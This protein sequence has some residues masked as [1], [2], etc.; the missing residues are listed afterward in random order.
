MSQYDGKIIYIKGKQN[1]IADALSWI[2]T[3]LLETTEESLEADNLAKSLFH[4]ILINGK[5]AAVLE[6]LSI[7]VIELAG[8]LAGTTA[9]ACIAHCALHHT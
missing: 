7:E 6:A 5:I 9:R 2:P 4:N 8:V 1:F 3:I